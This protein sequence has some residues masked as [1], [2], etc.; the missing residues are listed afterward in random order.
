[1]V[2]D[3]VTH[4]GV[5]GVGVTLWNRQGVLYNATTDSS[6]SFRIFDMQPGE[7]RSRYEKSGFVWLARPLFGEPTLRVGLG[8]VPRLTICSRAK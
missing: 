1:M 6:G 2:T 5:P 3:T 7:Y 4:A 8:G